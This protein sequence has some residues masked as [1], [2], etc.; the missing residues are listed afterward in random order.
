MEL[1]LCSWFTIEVSKS[2]FNEHKEDIFDNLEC[3]VF[4][5]CGNTVRVHV[6]PS[7]AKKESY[8]AMASLFEHISSS[9][10][11]DADYLKG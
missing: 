8:L 1:M 5:D 9:F 3:E 4:M 6:F 11:A 7:Y 2:F 10:K